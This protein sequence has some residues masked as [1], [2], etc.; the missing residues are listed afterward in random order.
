[1]KRTLVIFFIAALV[2]AV[3]V[4]AQQRGQGPN[5]PGNGV[6]PTGPQTTISGT[7]VSLTAGLGLGTPTLVLS[8]GGKEVSL[9]LGPYRLLQQSN[10]S[11]KAG[12]LVEAIVV[13]CSECEHE[14]FVVS[15]RNITNG[16][17]I[18]LD[19]TGAGAGMQR[20]AGRRGGN[21]P[22]NG[23][24]NCVGPDMTKQ[25]TFTGTIKSF[26]GGP[27]LGQPTL[28]VATAAGD[29]TVFAAPYRPFLAAGY[30]F[31]AG[32]QVTIVAAPAPAGEWVV[33]SLKDEATGVTFVLRDAQTGLPVSGGRGGRHC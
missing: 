17:A 6:P 28:V 24:Q 14:F 32:A 8:S 31:T 11:A 9:V 4:T 19:R 23:R 25:E 20:G 27:G 16:T 12:D 18:T 21:G 7:V 13:A 26:T 33:I 1:M 2:L 15:V 30:E 5:G 3:G 10:F 29:R 22:G